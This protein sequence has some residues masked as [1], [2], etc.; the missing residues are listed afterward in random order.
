VQWRVISQLQHE[1][2]S[3]RTEPQ[4]N[5]APKVSGSPTISPAAPKQ[6]VEDQ[7]ELLRLRNEVRQLREQVALLRAQPSNAPMTHAAASGVAHT[8]GEAMRQLGLAASRGEQG[9]LER[10]AELAEASI[11]SRTNDQQWVLGEVKVAFDTIGSEAGK[12]DQTAMQ[13]LWRA[14]RMPHLQGLAIRA[15][16]QAAAMGNESALEPLLE[17]E[18]YLLTTASTVSALKPAAENGNVRAI[19]A[20][21]AVAKDPTKRALG[22]MVADGLEK[23]AI[24]GNATAIDALA[25]LGQSEN[26]SVR[27]TAL[28]ALENS[29]FNQHPRA[30]EALRSLGYQ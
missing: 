14:T 27:R 16:G 20:L 21:A 28:R 26:Q 1:N 30:A 18:R 19:E 17:P 4:E 23:A 9:A 24:A 29:A 2:K 12:R 3:L 13:T 8:R 25:V 10:L 15:L 7:I 6:A 22:Y 5:V 11:K